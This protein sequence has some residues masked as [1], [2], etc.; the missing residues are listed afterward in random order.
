MW[1]ATTKNTWKLS[2][3]T[4]RGDT[5]KIDISTCNAEMGH[6]FDVTC[7]DSVWRVLAQPGVQ[8]LVYQGWVE[9][10]VAQQ[11]CAFDGFVNWYM[12][13]E[14]YTNVMGLVRPNELHLIQWGSISRGYQTCALHNQHM[15]HGEAVA[16]RVDPCRSLRA[17]N[18]LCT[19]ARIGKPRARAR[20]RA[21]F[22]LRPS[23][24]ASN[25]SHDIL[26]NAF[27]ETVHCPLR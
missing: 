21:D 12:N 17:V 3:A 18:Y 25:D 2:R 6:I 27:D 14:R 10:S 23:T 19:H 1:D 26:Y 13:I 16:Q 7:Y 5:A 9:V 24:H 15:K 22:E 4:T 20:I 8:V 11:K